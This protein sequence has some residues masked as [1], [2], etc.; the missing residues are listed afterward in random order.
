MRLYFGTAA[1]IL[2]GMCV[3]SQKKT[4]QKHSKGKSLSTQDHEDDGVRGRQERW[5]RSS[6]KL[7]SGESLRKGPVP[8]LPRELSKDPQI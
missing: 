6:E 1:V 7:G 2:H 8:F 3:C 4:G 5:S